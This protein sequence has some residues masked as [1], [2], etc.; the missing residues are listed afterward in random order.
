MKSLKKG[1]EKNWEKL[2]KVPGKGKHVLENYKGGY[3]N[4][5]LFLIL[6]LAVDKRACP[7]QTSIKYKV[8]SILA[9]STDPGK[10]ENS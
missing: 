8:F 6:I 1:K 4:I 7:K 10:F 3:V 2:E 9:N 5:E